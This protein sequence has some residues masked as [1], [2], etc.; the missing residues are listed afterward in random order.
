MSLINYYGVRQM[1]LKINNFIL[2]ISLSV[3]L[4]VFSSVKVFADENVSASEETEADI[5]EILVTA[6]RT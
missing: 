5:E 3:L 4:L 2:I 1:T 6:N